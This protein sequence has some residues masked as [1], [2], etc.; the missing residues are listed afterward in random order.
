MNDLFVESRLVGELLGKPYSGRS[1]EGYNTVTEQ[2]ESSFV[3]TLGPWIAVQSGACEDNGRVRTMVGEVPD[4]IW[5]G[6]LTLRAVYTFVDDDSYR[7]DAFL[8]HEDEREFK[9]LEFTA[10]R[11]PGSR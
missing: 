9:Q 3:E 4:P 1:I 7:Y 6:M 11:R 2:Y 10:S 8:S 5:G